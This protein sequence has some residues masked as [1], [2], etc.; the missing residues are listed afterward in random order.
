MNKL[1]PLHYGYVNID[2][3][4]MGTVYMYIY[5]LYFMRAMICLFPHES[6]STMENERLWAWALFVR[7]PPKIEPVSGIMPFI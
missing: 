1:E 6:T 5:I 3:D 4:M 2:G 7:N